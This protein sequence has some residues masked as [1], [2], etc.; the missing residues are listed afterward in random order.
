M[1]QVAVVSDQP[2]SRTSL[3]K[4]LYNHAQLRVVSAVPT[5]EDLVQQGNE[6]DV[7][8]LDLNRFTTRTLK[9]VS[10][11]GAAGPVLINSVWLD[12][13]TLLSTI[14]AGAR[15]CLSRHAEPSEVYASICAVANGGFYLSQEFARQFEMEVVEQVPQQYRSVLAP[16]E[17]ETLRFIASGM[18]EAQIA[19]RMGLSPATVNTYAKRI[20]AKLNVN[21]KAELTQMAFK[22]GHFSESR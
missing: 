12:S 14:L 15:G 3:E 9:A 22:L 1:F 8:V 17:V 16:R 11:A 5:V 13:P 18:T 21:N 2:P 4:L 20:R 6:C 19:R 10:A 7:V